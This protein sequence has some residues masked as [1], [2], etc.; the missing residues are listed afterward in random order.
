MFRVVKEWIVKKGR[1]DRAVRVRRRR[2]ASVAEKLEQYAEAAAVAQEGQPLLAQDLIQ[3]AKEERPKVLVVG[4]EECFSRPLAV[5]AVGLAKRMGY[6]LVA[7]ACVPQGRGERGRQGSSQRARDNQ[8]REDQDGDD[9]L[10]RMADEASVPI[11]RVEKNG[12]PDQCIAQLL[13][14]LR[15]VEFVLTESESIRGEGLNPALPVFCLS[16]PSTR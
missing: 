14:E 15:R 16:N 4:Q 12:R 10:G 8:P 1:K 2:A 9:L 7:L 13:G 11:R 3:R 6:E 5:Y